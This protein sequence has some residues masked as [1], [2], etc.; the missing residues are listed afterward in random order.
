MSKTYIGIAITTDR[1]ECV[2]IF[3]WFIREPCG[4]FGLMITLTW[5]ILP[6]LS[7]EII[8]RLKPEASWPCCCSEKVYWMNYK[9]K[10]YNSQKIL[11]SYSI[12]VWVCHCHMSGFHPFWISNTSIDSWDRI[13]VGMDF[14]GVSN[15][16]FHT[17][18]S[19]VWIRVSSVILVCIWSVYFQPILTIFPFVFLT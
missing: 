1:K 9:Q 4:V 7:R 18:I 12:F 13:K 8:E 11:W 17:R 15:P 14:W 6:S 16:L 5:V 2:G 3:L 19:K 10:I